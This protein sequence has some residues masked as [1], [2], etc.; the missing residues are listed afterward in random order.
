MASCLAIGVDPATDPLDGFHFR[1]SMRLRITVTLVHGP[2][3]DLDAR[4]EWDYLYEPDAERVLDDVSYT[5]PDRSGETVKID[6]AYVRG[7]VEELAKNTD[8][9]RFIL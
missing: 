7:E 9:S 8:L 6:S 5:A 3:S 4:H 1:A 2:T